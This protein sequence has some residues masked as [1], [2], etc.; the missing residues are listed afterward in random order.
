MHDIKLRRISKLARKNGDQKI[1]H[2]AP[3]NPE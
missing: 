1:K 3:L 2:S